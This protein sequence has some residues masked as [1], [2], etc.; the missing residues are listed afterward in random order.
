[1]KFKAVPGRVIAQLI[2][3]ERKT[4]S[5][6]LLPE[7]SMKDLTYWKA[8]VVDSQDELVKNNDVIIFGKYAGS[9]LVDDYV[10]VVVSDILGIL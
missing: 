3:E 9:T 6:I 1:M 2:K 10:S 8:C 4:E 5:G 7:Q